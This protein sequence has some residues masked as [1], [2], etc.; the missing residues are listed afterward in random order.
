MVSLDYENLKK[1]AKLTEEDIKVLGSVIGGQ[2]DFDLL[3]AEH[4]DLYT[5]LFNY[6]CFET[7]EMPYGTAK[8]RTGDPV[9]WI[10]N[11]VEREI[12]EEIFEDVSWRSKH[13][14]PEIVVR[15]KWCLEMLKKFYKTM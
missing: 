12:P 15:M 13:K 11:R 3:D 6:Y 10:L 5:R 7:A 4:D 2:V 14:Y 1:G 8:A 9:D